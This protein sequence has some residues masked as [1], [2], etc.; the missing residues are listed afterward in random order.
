MKMEMTR[1]ALSV[2][3]AVPDNEAHRHRWR[4]YLAMLR[5]TS[6]A[7][8][9]HRASSMGA[10]L[11]F[12]AS[13]SMAPMFV[14]VIAVAGFVFGEDA[15]RGEVVEQLSG[16]IGPNGAQAVQGLIE[17]ARNIG[18]GVLASLIAFSA[19][20]L[21]STKAF[22]ELKDSL[23][24]I[25]SSERATPSTL[26]NLLRG[27]LLSFGLI[28]TLGFLLLVSLLISASLVAL[29]K[30]WG[31][32]FSDVAW[33]TEG[34][35]SI[36]AFG[37]VATL[38]AFIY[39]W[40]PDATIAWR[41]VIVGALVTAGLFTLGKFLIGVYLGNSAIASSF[42]AAGSLIVILLWVY[43]SSQIF[44]F[45]AEFTRVYAERRGSRSQE[46]VLTSTIEKENTNET[47]KKEVTRHPQP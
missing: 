47:G 25:W 20:L 37:V 21:A 39:K 17:G 15:A 31:P 43:Y 12:Y 29:Q 35:N 3:H 26:I 16:L 2:N 30:Y 9:A 42:G 45:G 19:L 13:F 1:P 33:L 36:M 27:R 32:W 22:A 40:L 46:A 18:Q 14:I 7:W 4:S 34:I 24:V 5:A 28:L 11:A 23:D 44:F 6:A 41:D 38:F 8:S 10:S